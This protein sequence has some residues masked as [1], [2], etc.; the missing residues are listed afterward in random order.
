MPETLVIETLG[1]A[2]DG[3]AETTAGRVFVPFALPGET[4]VAEIAGD[5]ATAT[6]ILAPSA[7][8]TT[9]PCPH[10]GSCGGCSLQHLA[11]PAYL[12]WKTAQVAEA[13][14]QHGIAAEVQ[15][16]VPCRPGTRRRAVFTAERNGRDVMLGF[17][18][19]GS[20]EVVAV[21]GCLVVVPEIA[22]SLETLRA[23][24]APLVR[25]GRRIRVTVLATEN[26]LDV[27]VDAVGRTDRAA[28][29]ALPRRASGGPVARLTVDGE[30]VFR[31]AE[32]V[33]AA[34][35]A[36]L[37]PVPGGFVQA[38]AD[39][40]AAMADEVMAGIGDA[41]RIADL[42]AG[43]GTFT[44]RLARQAKVTAVESDAAALKALERATQRTTGIK[45]V[46]AARRDLFREPLSVNELK[47]FDA[48]VFDP[49][50]AGA[51]AQ[52][53]TLAKSPVP[54]VVAVSCNPATLARD[55]RILLDGGYR[56]V[57]VQP[58]DQ[59]LW[60]GHIEV[61]ATFRR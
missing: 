58:I 10:F 15:P 44:L 18:R 8:R 39:A 60:S 59:F 32:P 57:R 52:S 25:P 24:V 22:R 41:K 53:E 3:I 34:G 54:T 31:A 42:F 23:L 47:A 4:V 7:H 40:E 43:I 16:I 56:L 5:R 11:I 51:K 35:V 48:V 37:F 49:P 36:R 6:A 9:P 27:A 1:H 55:G 19:M 50:R 45:A 2:G 61:V 14:A 21:P 17:N 13:F 38:V 26:G 46:T 33:L 28:T 20:H 29:E 12:S 30:E